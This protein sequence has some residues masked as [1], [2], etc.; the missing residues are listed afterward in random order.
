[1]PKVT[2]IVPVYNVE[3]YVS[4]CLKSLTSQT[5]TD[6]EVLLIDDASSDSSVSI[7]TESIGAYTGDITFRLLRQS[8][9]QGMSAARNRGM[10]EAKGEY[11]YFLDSD[12]YI[13]KDCIEVLYAAIE[14][15]PSCRW[16]WETTG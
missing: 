15:D 5:F 2:I 11:L 12:D 1:M 6:L 3:Q 8:V 13:T 14:E 4:R 10:Q 16:P 9:N 7:I